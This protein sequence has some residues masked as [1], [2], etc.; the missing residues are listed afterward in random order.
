[1]SED[2]NTSLMTVVTFRNPQLLVYICM[3]STSW[4][5]TNWISFQFPLSVQILEEPHSVLQEAVR[6]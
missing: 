1:M 6:H 3:A 4:D 2:F 5:C